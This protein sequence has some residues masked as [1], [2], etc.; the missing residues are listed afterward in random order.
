MFVCGRAHSFAGSDGN[1]VLTPRGC[2]R[3]LSARRASACLPVRALTWPNSHQHLLLLK[4][5]VLAGVKYHLT[6]VSGCI[7]LM[8]QDV[9]VM[10]VIEHLLCASPFLG[11]RPRALENRFG[12]CPA[13]LLSNGRRQPRRTR[14]GG[15]HTLGVS[16]PQRAGG[17]CGLPRDRMAKVHKVI[18]KDISVEATLSLSP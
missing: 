18:R 15:G 3:P 6:G 8:T 12:P 14:E 17:R 2:C 11:P 16:A 1:S 13:E 9:E 5:A 7:S 4:V 10:I